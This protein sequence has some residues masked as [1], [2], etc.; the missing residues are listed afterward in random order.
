MESQS[1]PGLQLKS[2]GMARDQF[3]TRPGESSLLQC[4]W[5]REMKENLKFLPNYPSERTREN[6]VL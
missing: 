6:E 4:D 1:V 3:M 2:K 5:R